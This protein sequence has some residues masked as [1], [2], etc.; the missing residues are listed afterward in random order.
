MKKT[1]N[2]YGVAML[3]IGMCFTA[4]IQENDLEMQEITLTTPVIELS[5][6]QASSRADLDATTVSSA[7]L[8]LY[9]HDSEAREEDRK[10]VYKFSSTWT[11][12]TPVT[13]TGGAGNY[14]AGITA[15]ITLEN[16]EIQ[17]LN[18]LYGYKD[19][20]SVTGEGAFTPGGSLQPYSSAIAIKLKNANGDDISPNGSYKIHPVGLKK[21]NGFAVTDGKAFPNGDV[22]PVLAVVDYPAY[23]LTNVAYGDFVP[24]TY[25]NLNP[26]FEV[27]YCSGGNST[28]WTVNYDGE[29]KLEA[30]KLYTFTVTLEA[31]AHITLSGG[32]GK[33]G[34]GIDEEVLGTEQNENVLKEVTY[35][36]NTNTFRVSDANGLCLVAQY[37][38][39][40]ITAGSIDG[41]P[42]TDLLK[43]NITL[44][45]DI[46]FPEVEDG[47]SNWTPIAMSTIENGDFSDYYHGTIDGGGHKI[48][49]MR[50]NSSEQDMSKRFGLV[51]H[52]Y[53]TGVVK[54]LTFEDCTINGY[55]GTGLAVGYNY[56][57]T[58][59][60]CHALANCTVTAASWYAGG[61]V[62]NNA[63]SIASCT[64]AATVTANTGCAGGI[65]GATNSNGVIA[66]CS[67]TGHVSV[68]NTENTLGGLVG[69]HYGKMY[70][71]WSTATTGT[72]DAITTLDVV[73]T[74]GSQK[75]IESSYTTAITATYGTPVT[76]EALNTITD[77]EAPSS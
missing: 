8:T 20:I 35:D 5:G 47:E 66:A 37:M 69:E 46:N 26:L 67:A 28:T 27:I 10:G 17:I 22:A 21:C 32:L 9:L 31:D 61:I 42:T 44:T 72:G 18:A 65:T 45:A 39:G 63:G 62:G 54:N 48:T 68:T 41:W 40:E 12:T 25:T 36:A 60:N 23:E 50:V 24:G 6:I 59:I 33:P 7:D 16:A 70:G 55:Y 30:G 51:G 4:C 3:F 52:L 77:N 49:G 14:R 34:W 56:S 57:G 43:K 38:N 71:C 64:S 19:R 74:V 58:I 53:T 2:I 73:G 15:N 76:E 11:A 13:V 1:R 29:L 75:V